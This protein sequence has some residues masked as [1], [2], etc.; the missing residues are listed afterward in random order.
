[1]E[2]P[3]YEVMYYAHNKLVIKNFK[4]STKAFNFAALKSKTTVSKVSGISY[5]STNGE[6]DRHVQDFS[7]GMTCEPLGDLQ[8]SREDILKKTFYWT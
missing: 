4:S 2:R 1:M 5:M 3:Y 6:R 8:Y 7:Q